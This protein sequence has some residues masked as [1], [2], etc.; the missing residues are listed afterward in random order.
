LTGPPLKT[1]GSAEECALLCPRAFSEGFIGYSIGCV[2]CKS[3]LWILGVGENGYD[4]GVHIQKFQSKFSCLCI[5]ASIFPGTN[6][7]C[8]SVQFIKRMKT[9]CVKCWCLGGAAQKKYAIFMT[10][11]HDQLQPSGPPWR[12]GKNSHCICEVL[13]VSVFES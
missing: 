11:T 8:P 9:D 7:C 1:A 12:T 6:Y 3:K 4:M 5:Y 2:D 10:K 13:H